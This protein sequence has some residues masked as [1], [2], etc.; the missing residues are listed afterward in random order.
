MLPVTTYYK[1]LLLLRTSLELN[2]LTAI[3]Y[4]E[5]SVCPSPEA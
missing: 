1:K 5:K 3:F 4:P 2:K